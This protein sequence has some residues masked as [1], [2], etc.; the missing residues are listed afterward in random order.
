M[1]VARRPALRVPRRL[2][3]AAGVS[4]RAPGRH[5]RQRGAARATARVSLERDWIIAAF[6]AIRK[7]QSISVRSP[8]RAPRPITD[9]GRHPGRRASIEAAVISSRPRRQIESCLKPVVT[10]V[11]KVFAAVKSYRVRSTFA[12]ICRKG[13]LHALSVCRALNFASVRDRELIWA[14]S[15]LHTIRQVLLPLWRPKCELTIG[16]NHACQCRSVEPAATQPRRQFSP[17]GSAVTRLRIISV[18]SVTY[19]DIPLVDANELTH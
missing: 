12:K 11:G 8:A 4:T 16:K 5:R 2:R 19:M 10:R 7:V 13:A 9:N 15:K 6:R 17:H 3:T 18:R 1:R 14:L